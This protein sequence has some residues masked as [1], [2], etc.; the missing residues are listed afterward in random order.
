MNIR[1]SLVL[2]AAVL[3]AGIELF[4]APTGTPSQEG[5]PWWQDAVFYEIFVR[6]FYDSNGD[7]VGDLQ[8]IISKLDY[9]NTGRPGSQNSL[10]VTGIWLMPIYPTPS[11]HGYDVTN[12]K[13]VN[14]AYGTLADMHALIDSAHAR[15]IRVIIDF[16]PNHTST[17][18]PWFQQ[19]SSGDSSRYHNW[20]LWR[21]DNPGT[22]NVQGHDVWIPRNGSY[23]YAVFTG[24]MPDLNLANPDTKNAI[25]DAAAFW[26]DSVGVDGLRIDAVKHLF[27]DGA[28][29]EHASGTFTFL[30]EFRNFYKRAKPDAMTVAEVWS[31]S[32]QIAPYLDGTGVDLAFEFH[33]GEALVRALKFDRPREIRDQLDT[34]AALYPRNQ[35]GTFLTNH[36]VDRI[37]SAV[38]SDPARLK[39]AA[40][41]YL[42]LP[43]V[44]FLYYGE[45]I[46]MTGSGPDNRKRTPMQWNGRTKGGF[47]SGEPWEPLQENSAWLNV[48]SEQADSSSLWNWYHS[49]IALRRAH[50]A[51]SHG[52]YIPVQSSDDSLICWIRSAG[53]E[54]VLAVHSFRTSGSS[55][56][57]LSMAGSAIDAGLHDVTRLFPSGAGASSMQI[58]T[59]GEPG[60]WK[61]PVALPAHGSAVYLISPPKPRGKLE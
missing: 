50:P 55:Q 7:G 27:E 25:F 11:Y 47:T 21:K 2:F 35:Y 36:D 58:G 19:S 49:L 12:Y 5:S 6:S 17:Q 32:P 16:V 3:V 13:A 14:P 34:N 8:G 10:G 28:K 37:A 15:G 61:L 39:L 42:T 57:M 33:T 43:G 9:L 38:R 18:H 54:V 51:L 22:K 26:L 41:F 29:I 59:R 20:Y 40:A 30:R 46:G 48:Q 24:S 56:P 52:S 60:L 1:R 44:P 31:S 4:A 53:N 23:Y 45:E